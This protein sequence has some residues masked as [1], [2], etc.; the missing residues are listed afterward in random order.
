MVAPRSLF[1]VCLFATASASAAPLSCQLQDPAQKYLIDVQV[2]QAPTDSFDPV[3]AQ[4][5]LR[6]K[7]SGEVL[8]KIATA[9]AAELLTTD[10]AEQSLHC[11]NQRLLV[12]GDFNF[13]D[14]QDL[15]VRNG[16]DGG[17]AAASYD[18]YLA[19]SSNPVLMPNKEFSALTREPNLG[20]FEVDTAGK[21]LVT[22]SKS[23][24]CWRQRAGW[25]VQD[26][27]PVRVA[28]T[29][30]VAQAP[31]EANP[32]MPK[33]YTEITQRDLR[34]SQWVE[35]RRFV[36]PEGEAPVMLRGKL[37]D[38]IAFELWW[39]MQGAVYVGQVRYTGGNGKPIRLVGEPYDDGAVALHEISDE[40]A[41]TGNW[42]I[43]GEPDENGFQGGTWHSG[44]RSYSF[45]ARP[46]AFHI[47]PQKLAAVAADQREGRYVMATDDQRS[48]WLML[49]IM[50]DP[51]GNE[52]ASLQM[53]ATQPDKPATQVS[54]QWPL[55]AGN[56]LIAQK[57]I[58][59]PLYRARLLDGAVW[60]EAY[61]EYDALRGTYLKQ[62]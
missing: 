23:G 58:T 35:Q 20:M 2:E 5:I 45:D 22:Q 9:D 28:E 15:A 41:I 57:K 8:Q 36:G 12:F 60:V 48:A 39:Q 27:R 34:G 62:P 51:Q 30:E 47:A 46:T 21:R 14:Q 40:G 61:G 25:Q 32:F 7:A 43:A 3:A 17:Y 50:R 52:I 37:D 24:C 38:K 10:G 18:V 44:D 59:E 26:N 4:I 42:F 54:D 13:D 29:T 16:N 49:K 1:F 31:S 33:G 55:L 6:D 19:D 53:A 56:L 11:D